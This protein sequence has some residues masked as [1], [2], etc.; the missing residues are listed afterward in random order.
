[1]YD[2]PEHPLALSLS[3]SKNSEFTVNSMLIFCYFIISLGHNKVLVPA[4]L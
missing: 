4:L 2:E 3:P 1:M